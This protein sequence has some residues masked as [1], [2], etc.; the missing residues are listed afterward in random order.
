MAEK[1]DHN[2]NETVIVERERPKTSVWA[3]VAVMLLVILLA[4]FFIGNPLGGGGEG[5][6]DIDVNT[7]PAGQ[8]P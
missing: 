3:V 8:A 5:T 4:F 1:P 6:T 7:P 2:G